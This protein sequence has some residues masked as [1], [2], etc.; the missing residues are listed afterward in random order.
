M[1]NS[2]RLMG[3]AGAGYF[4]V[5]DM[6]SFLQNYKHLEEGATAETAEGLRR[7]IQELEEQLS[8][9]AQRYEMVA[10]RQRHGGAAY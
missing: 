5:Q 8:P 10:Q 1:A 7:L 4:L 9:L 3:V 6:N 2:A